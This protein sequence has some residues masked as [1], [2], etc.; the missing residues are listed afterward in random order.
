MPM[1][2]HNAKSIVG[3]PEVVEDALDLAQ[4]VENHPAWLS[5]KAAATALQALQVQ[6]GSIPASTG[7]A[8]GVAPVIGVSVASTGSATG[9]RGTGTALAA[10][11]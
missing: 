3:E 8:T 9:S 10:S 4:S 11:A 2:A 6:D 5:L 1:T 7:S